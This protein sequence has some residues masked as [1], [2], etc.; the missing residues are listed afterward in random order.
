GEIADA[1]DITILGEE[2]A[3]GAALFRRHLALHRLVSWF[4]GQ[5]VLNSRAVNNSPP[6]RGIVALRAAD[7]EHSHARSGFPVRR[8]DPAGRQP[9]P[10]LDADQ[11]DVAGE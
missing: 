1:G 5:E 2:P 8:H 7:G 6:C 4:P 9:A 3:A 11:T 10:G